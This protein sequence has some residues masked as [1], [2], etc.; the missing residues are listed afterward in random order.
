MPNARRVDDRLLRL[1]PI[2]PLVLL[3]IDDDDVRARFAYELNASGFNVA[4]TASTVARPSIIVTTLSADLGGGLPAEIR[5]S[6]P[7]FRGVPMIAIA[8]DAS[9]AMRNIARGQGCVA[10]CVTTCSGATLVAGMWA[11]LDRTR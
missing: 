7:R 9:N 4:V 6:D 10:L 11:V 1:T 3:A 8:P 5:T 2:R